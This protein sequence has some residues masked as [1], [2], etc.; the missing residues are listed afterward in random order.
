[1][2]LGFFFSKLRRLM[3]RYEGLLSALLASSLV[4]RRTHQARCKQGRD[5]QDWIPSHKWSHVSSLFWWDLSDSSRGLGFIWPAYRTWHPA[6][7]SSRPGVGRHEC[8]CFRTPLTYEPFF[9]TLYP[10]LSPN[11]SG[12][13]CAAHL[14][15]AAQYICS[16][17]R[18]H[19]AHWLL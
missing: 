17:Q 1:M 14:M 16:A 7:N 8:S 3:F 12:A 5:H 9:V 4:L 6:I 10:T 2:V 13:S 11:L 18:L 15:I 19:A